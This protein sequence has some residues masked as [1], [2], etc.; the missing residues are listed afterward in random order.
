VCGID[1][2][3]IGMGRDPLGGTTE[4]RKLNLF[5]LFLRRFPPQTEDGELPP[6]M[7]KGAAEIVESVPDHQPPFLADSRKAADAPH[8]CLR[9]V[10]KL[11]AEGHGD[12]FSVAVRGLLDVGA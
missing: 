7:V 6:Q 10:L 3:Q 4:D 2:Q 1:V 8:D 9:F 12:G 11:P 5:R